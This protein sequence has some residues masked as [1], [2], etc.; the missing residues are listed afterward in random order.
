MGLGP[1]EIDKGGQDDG[2]FYF[3]PCDDVVDHGTE[4]SPF[5]MP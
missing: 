3:S 1:I 2:K 4:G 5:G